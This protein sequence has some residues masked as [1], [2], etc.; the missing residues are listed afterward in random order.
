MTTTTEPARIAT[1]PLRGAA[2]AAGPLALGALALVLAIE[3]SG[4]STA[5]SARSPLFVAG[6][7][8]ALLGL[9]LLTF[10]L[11]GLRQEVG[12]LRHGLGRAG[13][14]VALVGSVLAA[15]GAWTQ[16]FV[17]PGLAAAAP[18]I[19]DSGLATVVAGYV[20][21]YLLLGVGWVVVG[22]Y[23]VRSRA[24]RLGGWL[25]IAGAV[26]CIAPPLFGLRWALLAVGISVVALQSRR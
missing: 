5:E 12:G 4:G 18:E 1:W 21:S 19:A 2:L 26:L 13:W 20:V 14:V 15:G 8:A 22:A 9:T 7:V 6:S 17:L 3:G 16:L 11:V 10:A 25:V 23:I 24:A